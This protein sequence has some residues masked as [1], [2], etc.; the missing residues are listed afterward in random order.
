MFFCQLLFDV[1]IGAK[2]VYYEDQKHGP[3]LELTWS[4]RSNAPKRYHVD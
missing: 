1:Y 3:S 4:R 2:V